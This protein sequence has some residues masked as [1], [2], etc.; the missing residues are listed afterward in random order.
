MVKVMMVGREDRCLGWVSDVKL[1]QANSK[2]VE[3]ISQMT[4]SIHSTW[5]VLSLDRL[6]DV[7]H[8]KVDRRV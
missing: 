4:S 6:L 3:E 2:T 7:V 5:F 8:S 1:F